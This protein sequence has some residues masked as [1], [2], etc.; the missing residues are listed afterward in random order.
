MTTIEVESFLETFQTL[1]MASL[2]PEGEPHASTAPYIRLEN[3]FYI[4]ISTVAQ[5]GRNLL[6]TQR[7]SLLFAEDESQCVQP[8]ARKRVTIEAGV[9]E[10]ESEE[11]KFSQVIDRFKAHFDPELVA[12]LC[13]MGDFHL[14][15]LS[16]K[17]GSVVMGFGKAYRLNEN[18]DVVTHISAQHQHKR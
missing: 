9:S 12:S 13:D 11:E 16:P 14:F 3:D 4:L 7:V 18:L 10:V 5:H 17:S 2:T 8:F 1:V 6:E 15:K